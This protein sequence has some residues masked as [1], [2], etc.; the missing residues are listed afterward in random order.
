MI[1][2]VYQ[3]EANGIKQIHLENYSDEE[4]CI[5]KMNFLSTRPN[6]HELDIREDVLREYAPT[7]LGKWVT[8]DMT[9]IID[10]STHTGR[11]HIV[12][13]VPNG[14]EVEFI[15]ADD[16][17]LDAWVD[18]VIS[19]IYARDYCA[20]FEKHNH[21]AVSVEMKTWS[22]EGSNVLE[23]FNIFAVTTLGTTVRPAVPGANIQFV[24]FSENDADEFYNMAHSGE[25]AK[26]ANQRNKIQMEESKSYKINKSKDALSTDDWGDVDKSAMRNKIM[27]AKNR[28]AL[29]KA[30]YL[31]VEDGW[32]DA[33]SEHLKYP[34]M[35]LKGDT[36]VY[37]RA[38]LASA[39]GYAE[40]NNEQGVVNKIH[41]IY[42]KL[43]IDSKEKEDDAKMSD[44]EKKMAEVEEDKKEEMAE[45]ETDEKLEAEKE[46]CAE[47]EVK[48]DDDE[49]DDD[50]KDDEDKSDDDDDKD[51]EDDGDKE[52]MAA[53]EVAKLKEDIES[54][55]NIIMEKDKE[56]EELRKF[57]KS[58]EDK[59]RAMAVE[60]VM[61]EISKFITEDKAKEFRAEGLACDNETFSAWSNKVKAYSFEVTKGK[62]TKKSDGV[63]SFAAPGY[64]VKKPEDA[65]TRLKNR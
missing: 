56:L 4:F 23:Q 5:A 14:Q 51:D 42:K 50:K 58:V 9:N 54:R 52:E 19:K 45:T 32:K 41:G 28:D 24:R 53:D 65:W 3:F 40:K 60:T 21:R 61:E 38:A 26:F 8:A 33:P 12:G 13:I 6:S 39:L 36:F 64:S 10:A 57:K 44:E 18:V 46:T 17:Y 43:N 11:Q 30:V 22:E 49:D 16:G 35:Q 15:E 29:V 25:L 48:F 20:M 27:A 7:V 47:D 31:L 63:F 1:Q 34:V 59:E 55:D 2:N 37:N 62:A